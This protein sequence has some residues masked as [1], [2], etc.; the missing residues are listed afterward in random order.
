[1]LNII[2]LVL[3]ASGFFMGFKRGLVLQLVHLAGFVI[4]YIVAFMYYKQLTPT[5]K[6]WVPFPT[7]AAQ[8]G[9]FS[10]LGHLDLQSAYYQ[11]IAFLILFIATKIVLTII[12][13]M[14]DFL[15]EL[16]LIRSVNHLAGGLFGFVE[17]YLVVF[18]LLYVGALTPI[19]G[20]QSSIDGSSLAQSI[21]GSTP[22]FSK[23]LHQMWV[24]IA[25]VR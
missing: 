1:M 14:L 8:S 6:L 4:A 18:I 16:P 25:F 11:A 23:M 17:F 2:I 3:L 10:F 5:I 22:V 20:L 9:T 7:S 13:H 21:I 12:G 24:A 19:S 15:A